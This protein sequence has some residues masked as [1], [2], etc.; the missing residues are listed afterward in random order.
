MIKYHKFTQLNHFYKTFK[1]K[2]STNQILR[3]INLSGYAFENKQHT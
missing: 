3:R 2:I 1:K